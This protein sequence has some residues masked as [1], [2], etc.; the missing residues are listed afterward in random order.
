MYAFRRPDLGKEASMRLFSFS[1]QPGTPSEVD[2]HQDIPLRV[3]EQCSNQAEDHVNSQKPPVFESTAS[4]QVLSKSHLNLGKKQKEKRRETPSQKETL[5]PVPGAS[6]NDRYVIGATRPSDAPSSSDHKYLSVQPAKGHGSS[7]LSERNSLSRPHQNSAP[8]GQP[9]TSGFPLVQRS[10]MSHYLGCTTAT[11]R[12]R[13]HHLDGEK[14]ARCSL[15]RGFRKSGQQAG[16]M[17]PALPSYATGHSTSSVTKERMRLCMRRVPQAVIIVTAKNINDPQRPF[18]GATVSSFTTVTFEPE[19]IVSLNFKTPS[20]TFDA[21]R[22]SH[23][24]EVNMLKP[25]G[26]GAGLASR[27]ARGHAASPF[28]E[29]GWDASMDSVQRPQ[30][31]HHT[32]PPILSQANG[33]RNPV[34]FRISCLYMPE[35]TVWLGDHVVIFATV[36]SIPESEF[37]RGKGFNTCLA[38]VGGRYG[39]VE[40]LLKQPVEKSQKVS[41]RKGDN[42]SSANPTQ[43]SNSRR[44]F[45]GAQGHGTVSPGHYKKSFLST[46]HLVDLQPQTTSVVG[47]V[48]SPAPKVLQAIAALS[49]VVKDF[50]TLLQSFSSLTN[51]IRR[52]LVSPLSSVTR[53]ILRLDCFHTCDGRLPDTLHKAEAIF[54]NWSLPSEQFHMS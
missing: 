5:P 9:N 23:Y 18:R 30:E 45:L 15:I 31:T 24:F 22:S 20:A 54:L 43:T 36:T 32:F 4:D 26:M 38:Y 35:K 47:H 12:T 46:A 49:V 51:K 29:V 34:A 33:V 16:N 13:K 53:L 19:V 28:G 21:I 17:L 2:G 8:T 6:A 40:P 25:T 44:K 42:S 27:F 11:T 52:L 1:S 7:R 14:R 3:E 37:D 10:L 48:Q 41:V 39:R 50:G